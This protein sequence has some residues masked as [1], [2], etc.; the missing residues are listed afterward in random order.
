MTAFVARVFD[1]PH[2]ELAQMLN[3]RE[4]RAFEQ[5]RLATAAPTHSA[6]LSAT[7]AIPGPVKTSPI[8]VDVFDELFHEAEY[9]WGSA[10]VYSCTTSRANTGAEALAVVDIDP[11]ELKRLMVKLEQRHHWG[12]LADFDV[13]DPA[14]PGIPLSR[15]ELGYAPRSCLICG[16]E[17]KLCARSRAH[18]VREMQNKVATIIREGGYEEHDCF[19]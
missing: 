15:T 1:G 2:V 14:V 6:L 12:R 11:I 4:Q 19:R 13:F 5:K 16:G 9:M 8:L 7:L 3:A 18:T 10:R 17:A